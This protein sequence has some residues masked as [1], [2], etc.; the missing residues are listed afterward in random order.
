MFS[1]WE[2]SLLFLLPDGKTKQMERFLL[3]PFFICKSAH[4]GGL[5]STQTLTQGEEPDP[6]SL[7]LCQLSHHRHPNTLL[8][9]P[10]RPNRSPKTPRNVGL[11][12][13]STPRAQQICLSVCLLG[14]THLWVSFLHSQGS[15]WLWVSLFGSGVLPQQGGGAVLRG[16]KPAM[17]GFNPDNQSNPFS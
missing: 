9:P 14:R 15:T 1:P 13:L 3:V 11:R 16:E 17:P 7:S 2:C 6:P 12:P 8:I 5:W 10:P 4:F